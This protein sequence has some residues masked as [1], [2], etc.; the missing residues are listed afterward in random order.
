M[1]VESLE[2]VQ[3]M[4]RVMSLWKTEL[5]TPKFTRQEM[6]LITLEKLRLLPLLKRKKSILM[7]RPLRLRLA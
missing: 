3:L 2:L 6:V 4:I 1:E 7:V 5:D